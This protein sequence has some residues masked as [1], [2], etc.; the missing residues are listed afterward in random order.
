MFQVNSVSAILPKRF[1]QRK[2]FEI[3]EINRNRYPSIGDFIRISLIPGRFP[4]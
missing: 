1:I 3:T 2:E 4:V